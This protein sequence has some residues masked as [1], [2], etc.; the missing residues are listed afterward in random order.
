MKNQ[1][2]EI[3][4]RLRLK[5]H[6]EGGYYK[7]VYRSNDFCLLKDKK[8]N[9]IK[10]RF[11]TSIYYLLNGNDFSA[12]HKLKSDE[13]W[14]FYEGSALIINFFD[15]NK[16]LKKIILGE[17]G[18]EHFQCVIKKGTWFSA[19]VKNKNSFC[20]VGCTVSPGFEFED[21]EM[22]TYNKLIKIYPAHK[23]IIKR[24]TR[25]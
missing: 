9:Q 22:G 7:E 17:K 23:K 13:I 11:S 3:I 18:K 15:K 2:K 4:K 19:E 21:F 10:R 20:L 25:E 16:N 6:K 14:H 12:F 8:N 24:M 1:V 5:P